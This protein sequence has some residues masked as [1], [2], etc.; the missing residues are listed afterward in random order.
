TN[1][2]FASSQGHAYHGLETTDLKLTKPTAVDPK[3][4]DHL[5]AGD[6]GN[7]YLW[8][9]GC[10]QPGPVHI[11]RFVSLEAISDNPPES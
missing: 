9:G 11:S 10:H 2:T 3:T 8:T 4:N 1:I 5:A 7:A 6:R